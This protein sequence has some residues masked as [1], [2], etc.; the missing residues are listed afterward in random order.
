ME[1]SKNRSP[2]EEVDPREQS[3]MIWALTRTRKILSSFKSKCLV[4]K[5]PSKAT[6]GAVYGLQSVVYGL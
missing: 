4:Q 3:D 5:S 6:C 2:E 1:V